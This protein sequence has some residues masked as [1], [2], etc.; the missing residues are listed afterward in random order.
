MS[1]LL[2]GSYVEE[3][4]N[5]MLFNKLN[6]AQPITLLDMRTSYD[7][8]NMKRIRGSFHC[9]TVDSAMTQAKKS[10]F[11]ED[12]T[13][14]KTVKGMKYFGFLFPSN[15][16]DDMK[17]EL[18]S[19]LNSLITDNQGSIIAA[20][21]C[22]EF[23]AP[24]TLFPTVDQTQGNDDMTNTQSVEPTKESATSSNFKVKVYSLPDVDSFLQNYELCDVLFESGTTKRSVRNQYFATELIPNFL[25]LG[26]YENATNVEQ[27]K[28]MQITH[29]IDATYEHLSEQKALSLGIKYLPVD[30]WDIEDADISTFLPMT[31]EFIT[32]AMAENEASISNNEPKSNRVL[33][34][35]RA[36]WSRSPS[37][38]I[39][40]LMKF[41]NT[42]LL[43]TTR[44]VVKQRPMVC[45]NSGF[46]TQLI[47]YEK[48]R[49]EL[50]QHANLPH[51]HLLHLCTNEEELRLAICQ[52]SCLWVSSVAIETEFDR[53]P[54]NAFKAKSAMK[55]SMYPEHDV[56]DTNNIKPK[57]PFLKRGEGK[58]TGPV[59][60]ISKVKLTSR[61]STSAVPSTADEEG[62]AGVESSSVQD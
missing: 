54:I 61:G 42:T 22:Q 60:S 3:L 6:N 31:N 34:H 53:I 15:Y 30:I 41:W 24:T 11:G 49:L 38:V 56:N 23:I 37:I 25:Y 51:H 9:P 33:V 10:L 48:D 59:K 2:D 5:Y 26:D 52:E 62:A 40:F 21:L 50:L 12:E 35:C 1:S 29:I 19:K 39:A 4:H 43:T 47:S 17:G 36:G 8:F 46:R 45:P 20:D 18:Y 55:A 57:K 32:Q 13:L 7:E 58:K 44:Q 16:S 28:A 27:L 14:F